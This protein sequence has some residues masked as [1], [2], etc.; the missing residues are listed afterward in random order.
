MDINGMDLSGQALDPDEAARGG[1]M[2]PPI[3]SD[4]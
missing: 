4:S 2:N 3:N 1:D